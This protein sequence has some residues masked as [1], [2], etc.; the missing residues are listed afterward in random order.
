MSL[1]S[2]CSNKIQECFNSQTYFDEDKVQISK[3]LAQRNPAKKDLQNLIQ[4]E[5]DN[6]KQSLK[7][8]NVQRKN[9]EPVP[10]P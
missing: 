6:K 10:E 4:Q 5:Y 8:K 9:I 3:R 2:L 7:R 1:F